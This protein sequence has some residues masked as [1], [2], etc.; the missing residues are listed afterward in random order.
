[1]KWMNLFGNI[2]LISLSLTLWTLTPLCYLLVVEQ[3]MKTK[4]Y[5]DSTSIKKA[6]QTHSVISH[7]SNIPYQPIRFKESNSIERY[8][9]DLIAYGWNY[10]LE[11]G[12]IPENAEWLARF[13][14]TRASVRA[15]DVVEEV[16]K[17]ENF[18]VKSFLY[19]EL[20]KEDG[21]HGLP[22]QLMKESLELLH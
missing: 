10:F 16:T 7:V 14:M 4:S 6:I 15:M 8:E 1:M 18:P 12:G 11:K 22:Q 17:S 3:K 21:R 19:L 5:L 20:L 9:D 2:G 13:P